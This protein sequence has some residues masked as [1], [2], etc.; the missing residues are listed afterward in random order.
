MPFVYIARTGDEFIAAAENALN[1]PDKDRI[2]RGLELARKSSW[3]NT[4]ESMQRLIQEAIG[5]HERRSKQ[6]IT[7]LS[8]A[9]LSYQYQPTPG[10]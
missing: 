4:V 2:A 10:S 5:K 7:P 6:K 8:E 9:E 3:E 1:N